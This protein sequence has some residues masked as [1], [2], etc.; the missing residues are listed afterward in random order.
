MSDCIID[1]Q[2]LV[3]V[4]DNCIRSVFRYLRQSKGYIKQYQCYMFV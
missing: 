4:A 2:C 3:H 1:L